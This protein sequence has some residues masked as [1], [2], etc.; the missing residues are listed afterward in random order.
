M[1]P[2]EV[3]MTSPQQA[4]AYLDEIN[5]L[6][7]EN[8]KLRAALEELLDDVDGQPVRLRILEQARAA[9]GGKND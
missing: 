3:R 9:L 4:A 6:A 2:L 5:R 7:A 1:L 8:A